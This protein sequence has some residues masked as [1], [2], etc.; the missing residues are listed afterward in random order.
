MN[1]IYKH[2]KHY[3][4]DKLWG[5]IQICHRKTKYDEIEDKLKCDFEINNAIPES[6]YKG[7]NTAIHICKVK[8]KELLDNTSHLKNTCS[9]F[10]ECEILKTAVVFLFLNEDFSDND[11]DIL[12][13][14]LQS[15]RKI[16]MEYRKINGWKKDNNYNEESKIYEKN[17]TVFLDRIYINGYIS[18][19]GEY[20][21]PISFREITILGNQDIRDA[22]YQ[23]LSKNEN[24]NILM[25]LEHRKINSKPYG[26]WDYS[27]I[28]GG[29]N[30]KETSNEC[31]IR[32]TYEESGLLLDY[33]KV[34]SI[35]KIVLP[36]NKDLNI[37]N[38]NSVHVFIYNLT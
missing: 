22:L 16:E 11:I 26:Q 17:N 23:V 1:N 34:I 35:K 32:E 28:G 13:N 25:L 8:L 7:P 4:F 33:N 6:V 30:R 12:D 24:I 3:K 38:S 15:L 27:I 31:I 9:D 18:K 19:H 20:R 5:D 29:I 2:S 14:K 21:L 36:S 37:E 10:E